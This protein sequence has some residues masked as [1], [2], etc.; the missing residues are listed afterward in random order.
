MKN[1][2]NSMRKYIFLCKH[3]KSLKIPK[4]KSMHFYM[5]QNINKIISTCGV[6]AEQMRITLYIQ[7]INIINRN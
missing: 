6:E 4:I 2:I 7:K 1:K 3:F 5:N